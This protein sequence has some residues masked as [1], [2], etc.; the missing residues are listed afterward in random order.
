MCRANYTF[1]ILDGVYLLH[2]D[3]AIMRPNHYR[4]IYKVLVMNGRRYEDFMRLL[5]A[6]YTDAR[7]RCK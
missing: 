4:R 3:I 7:T 6:K 5:D 1:N 2:K